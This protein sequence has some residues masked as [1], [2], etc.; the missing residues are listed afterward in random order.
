M[1]N[2]DIDFL[3]IRLRYLIDK[4]SSTFPGMNKII[5]MPINRLTKQGDVTP[6]GDGMHYKVI[7]LPCY[8]LTPISLHIS[9]GNYQAMVSHLTLLFVSQEVENSWY[10]DRN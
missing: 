8:Y 5:V 2:K 3:N 7:E 9:Q 4:F 1:N 6:L 10:C